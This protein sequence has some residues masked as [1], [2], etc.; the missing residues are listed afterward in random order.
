MVE[1]VFE[2]E[3]PVEP[4]APEAVR[5]AEIGPRSRPRLRPGA[6][7]EAVEWRELVVVA[8]AAMILG[9]ANGAGAVVGATAA[10]RPPEPPQD[11]GSPPCC[12]RATPEPGDVEE[13]QAGISRPEI[14]AE[15]SAARA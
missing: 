4:A 15:L 8:A 2:P 13:C 3:I 7:P 14:R 9:L 6:H 10:E 12:E 11:C 1:R 5:I